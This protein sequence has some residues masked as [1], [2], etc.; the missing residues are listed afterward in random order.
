MLLSSIAIVVYTK[1][2]FENWIQV[3]NENQNTELSGKQAE[4]LTITLRLEPSELSD[5]TRP[6]L[7]SKANMRPTAALLLTGTTGCDL[8]TS[9][10]TICVWVYR[11]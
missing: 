2:I 9:D 8:E 11:Y 5:K 1:E 10:S 4:T 6:P 7:K 3:I